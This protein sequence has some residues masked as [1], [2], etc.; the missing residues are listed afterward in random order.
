MLELGVD[1]DQ[2]QICALS[3]AKR[4]LVYAAIYIKDKR[5]ERVSDY[6]L[7][8]IGTVLDRLKGKTIF[9]GDGVALFRKDIEK[10]MKSDAV[11]APEKSWYPQARHLTALA[12]PRL[13]KKDFDRIE[14]LVPLYLYPSD[15]QVSK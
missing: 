2:G 8:D 4:N 3:D 7:T 11:F 15:C 9:T 14:T 12:R 10:K 5:L 1:Q 13:Q 6:F